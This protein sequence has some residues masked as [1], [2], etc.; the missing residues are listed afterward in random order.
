MKIF[1]ALIASALMMTNAEASDNFYS[2]ASHFIG[3]AVMAG[4]VTTI[5]AQYYPEYQKDRGMIGFGVSSVFIVLDQGLEAAL[6]GDTKG[7]MLDAVSHI[8]GSALGAYITD[9]YFLSPIIIH[10]ADQKRVAGLN[11]QYFF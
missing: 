8:A 6:Y 7:Q 11:F 10:S 4:G 9:E 5:V 3:G 2:E 1:R